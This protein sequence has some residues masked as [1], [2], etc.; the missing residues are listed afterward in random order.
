MRAT[1][2]SHRPLRRGGGRPH[3]RRR[4]LRNVRRLTE[5]FVT[6]CQSRYPLRPMA[7]L[8]CPDCR[9]TV[10]AT[11]YFVHGD[12]CPRC[13]TPMEPSDRFRDAPATA[14][15]AA[16]LLASEETAALGTPRPPG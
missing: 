11:A 3:P 10:R 2:S 12:R 8:R 4:P 1:A 5:G 13:L 15:S 16:A 14:P 9:L 7:F 6:V